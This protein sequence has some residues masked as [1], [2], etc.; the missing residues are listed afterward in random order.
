MFVVI[1]P[2]VFRFQKRMIFLKILICF[3][4]VKKT[5]VF[6]KNM[7]MII[8]ES[9]ISS[10]S[11]INIYKLGAKK[12]IDI[13]NSNA[14]I[15]TC[16]YCRYFWIQPNYW[17]YSFIEFTHTHWINIE[18]IKMVSKWW[19]QSIQSIKTVSTHYDNCFRKMSGE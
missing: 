3:P 8:V 15:S 5:I 10:V 2:K 7:E 14:L 1:S 9:K 16:L 12:K 4:W 19:Q 13:I 6:F 17:R 18:P 11:S